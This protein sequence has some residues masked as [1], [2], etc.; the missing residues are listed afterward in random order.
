LLGNPEIFSRH[1]CDFERKG[2]PAAYLLSLSGAR[3]VAA[4]GPF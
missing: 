1:V 3:P 4:A 2:S